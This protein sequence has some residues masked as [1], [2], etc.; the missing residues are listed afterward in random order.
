[1]CTDLA[2][3]GACWWAGKREADPEFQ[4][5]AARRA[6]QCAEM[7][8]AMGCDAWY[9][10]NPVGALSRLWR[11]PDHVFDPCEYGGYLSEMD[12]HPLY[13]Q[14]IHSLTRRLSKK[15]VH[16]AWT[17]VYSASQE[18]SGARAGRLCSQA[19]AR[20]G[21]VDTRRKPPDSVGSRNGPRTSG[22]RRPV[23]GRGR[24]LRRITFRWGETAL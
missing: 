4:E 19:H 14:H 1:M 23:G 12:E 21:L 11:K 16:L 20:A 3:S 7:A 22:R 2:A 15:D 17:G 24:C 5:R 9:V 6:M 18:A 10:E 8:E 13:P